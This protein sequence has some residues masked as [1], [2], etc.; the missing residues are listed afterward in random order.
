MNIKKTFPKKGGMQLF[1]L[2]DLKEFNCSMCHRDKKSKMVAIKV[3]DDGDALIC[4]GCYGQKLST[5]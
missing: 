2:N 5:E 1:R 3:K 4:N